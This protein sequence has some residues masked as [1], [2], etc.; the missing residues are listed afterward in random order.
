MNKQPRIPDP[1]TS[2]RLLANLRRTRLEVQEVNLELG[3][4]NAMLAEQLRQQRLN[5]VRRALDSSTVEV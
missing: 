1:E 3:E 2:K 4:I 5:R